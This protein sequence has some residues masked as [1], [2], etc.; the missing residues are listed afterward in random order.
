MWRTL[1]P[2]KN[3]P[4]EECPRRAA[5]AGEIIREPQGLEEPGA[6]FTTPQTC[7]EGMLR[8]HQLEIGAISP[9]HIQALMLQLSGNYCSCAVEVIGSRDLVQMPN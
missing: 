1:G 4:R 6:G 3:L 9:Q 8:Q 5:A 2:K 7:R